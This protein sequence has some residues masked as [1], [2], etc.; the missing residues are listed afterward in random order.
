M[1]V[2]VGSVK[3]DTA[4]LDK[5]AAEAKPKASQIVRS[6][7]GMITSEAV[8]RAPVDTG[9]LI[10]SITA[11][12]K[13]VEPLTYRIQDGVEYG[14]F[15]E[16]GTRIMAAHPFLFPALEVYR[17]KFLNAFSELFK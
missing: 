5:M 15:Q 3:I 4:K 11:N 7:G 10:N 8:K 1:A 6:Y 2:N 16:L 13:L 17:Q 14:I 9:A 12:S